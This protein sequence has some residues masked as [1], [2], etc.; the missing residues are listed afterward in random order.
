M[1]NGYTGYN[2][3][4]FKKEDS[5]KQVT[6][7][8]IALTHLYGM[9][10]KNKVVEIYNSQ[11]DHTIGVEN[12]EMYFLAP[13]KELEDN[14][15]ETYKDY[16]VHE[17]IMEFDDFQRMLIQKADKPYYVPRQEELLKYVDDLYF[18]R[19]KEY[20]ALLDYLKH[21]LF[22][23]KVD[24]AENLC[25]DIQ[26]ICQ[27]SFSMQEIFDSVNN[28]G[29]EFQDENQVNELVQMITMLSNSTRLW[30]NNGFTPNEIFAK[31]DRPILKKVKVG[32]NDPCP[33]G[34]GK[35]YKKCCL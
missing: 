28:F 34:S 6:Q 16:F 4:F 10:Q 29:I 27:F 7:Y 30:E 22:D 18:E 24:Q 2:K 9:V 19:N 3:I 23:G 26:G 13:S 5:M 15:V 21:N 32:R 35:K 1:G 20:K 17:S 31:Y 25:E 33:C 11:N 8:I 14:F 12:V